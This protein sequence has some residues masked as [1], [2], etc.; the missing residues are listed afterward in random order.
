MRRNAELYNEEGSLI[1][2][3]A[4]ILVNTL[5]RFISSASHDPLVFYKDEEGE[6]GG[7]GV[8]E[9]Q[10]SLLSIHLSAVTLARTP[11]CTIPYCRPSFP[12]APLLTSHFESINL[13]VSFFHS[14]ALNP[15]S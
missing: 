6:E 3:H 15:C 4:R 5:C 1:V 13:L 14:L 12:P 7:R 11:T 9:G 10:F 8:E 2:R